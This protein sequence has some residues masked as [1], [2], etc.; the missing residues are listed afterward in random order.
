MG[1]ASGG[2]ALSPSPLARG[3]LAHR[4][5]LR[6]RR[7]RDADAPALPAV[8]KKITYEATAE[9]WERGTHK[10]PGNGHV[11]TENEA[12]RNSGG[13]VRIC[14]HPVGVASFL[15]FVVSW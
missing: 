13:V 6:R 8:S 3:P 7:P 12:Q 14:S 15:A 4:A 1:S 2:S 10:V 9:G 11:L 5:R